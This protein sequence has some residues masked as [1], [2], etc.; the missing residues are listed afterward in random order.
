[1][2][3][4]YESIWKFVIFI[5][6]ENF[7]KAHVKIGL[8]LCGFATWGVKIVYILEQHVHEKMMRC[9]NEIQRDMC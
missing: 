1:M 7:K 4:T 5:A 6:K 8:L 9:L 3:S 2:L